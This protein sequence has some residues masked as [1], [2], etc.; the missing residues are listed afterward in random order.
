MAGYYEVNPCMKNVLSLKR[1]TGNPADGIDNFNQAVFGRV[2]QDELIFWAE[3]TIVERGAIKK[4]P[5]SKMSFIRGRRA[6]VLWG[7]GRPNDMPFVIAS[8]LSGKSV[9]Y[10]INFHTILF[11]GP[12]PWKIRTPWFLRKFI[13]N[14]ADRIICPSAAS[15]Q[16]VKNFFPKK[17]VISILNGVDST[18]FSPERKNERYLSEKYQID[19]SRPV[20]AFVGS[21][22]ER[23]RPDLFIALAKAMPS[24]NF[25]AV[26]RAIPEFDALSAA[27]GMKNFHWVPAM[28]REDIA[29]FLASA[30]AF[31]FPSLN[32]ASAAVILEAMASGAVPVVSASGGNGEFFRDGISGF[33]IP[34]SD[35]EKA[36]FEKKLGMLL[37]DTALH[38]EMSRAAREEAERHSWDEAAKQYTSALCELP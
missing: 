7:S 23:K 16:S 17:E 37:G 30:V 2:G 26:G 25:V 9:P 1:A 38:A 22:H 36:A 19:F 27:A 3:G 29:A 31:V 13:F 18:F 28:P 14:R 4:L 11:R 24:A 21:L 33:T 12:G 6:D 20:L 32:D 15:A 10:V 8:K 35:G 34:H 5:V